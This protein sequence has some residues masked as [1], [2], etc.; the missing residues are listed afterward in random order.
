VDAEVI[1][2][3]VE[4]LARVGLRDFTLLL[5]QS[6]AGVQGQFVARLREQLSGVCFW[7]VRRLPAAVHCESASSAR[8]QGG[9]RPASH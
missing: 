9:A 4:L 8:L 7:N 1:E 5:T 3:V 6:A 2:M